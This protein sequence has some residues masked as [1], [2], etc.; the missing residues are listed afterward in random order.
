VLQEPTSSTARYVSSHGEGK[1]R[2]VKPEAA[3]PAGQAAAKT[4]LPV[5]VL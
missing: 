1:G 4:Q 3:V 2:S 5:L